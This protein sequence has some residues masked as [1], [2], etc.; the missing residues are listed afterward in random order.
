MAALDTDS[1]TLLARH[2]A[3]S[4]AVQALVERLLLASVLTP[5]DLVQLREFGLQWADHLK[6]YGSTGIQI[7]GDRLDA[8]IREWWDPMG[9]PA[10]MERLADDS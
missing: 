2:T 7:D 9:V 3:V 8:E 1:E 6:Q 4:L 10:R 5:R